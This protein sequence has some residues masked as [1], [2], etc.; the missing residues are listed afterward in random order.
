M[1][2]QVTQGGGYDLRITLKTG[3]GTHGTGRCG[4]LPRTSIVDEFDTELAVALSGRAD[5][6]NAMDGLSKSNFSFLS[7]LHGDTAIIT[8]FKSF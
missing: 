8:C 3:V 7:R 2:G 6:N 5:A 1:S 4:F